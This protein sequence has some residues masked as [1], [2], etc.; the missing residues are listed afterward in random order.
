MGNQNKP[1]KKKQWE[2][3]ENQKEIGEKSKEHQKDNQRGSKDNPKNT[4]RKPKGNSKS[5]EIISLAH[6]PIKF[7]SDKS[8]S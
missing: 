2:P 6:A 7:T 4:H 3:K 8:L 1:S 5:T